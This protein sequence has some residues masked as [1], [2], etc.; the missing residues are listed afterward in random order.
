MFT[1]RVYTNWSRCT[2]DEKYLLLLFMLKLRI[3]PF[4]SKKSIIFVNTV[5]KCY[6]LKLFLERFGIKSCA[7]NAELPIKSRF[8]IV[9]EFNRGIYDFLIATDE[10]NIK[11]EVEEGSE[12]E[13]SPA[14]QQAAG[15]KKRKKRGNKEKDGEYGVSRGIDFKNVSAVINFDIP[16][17][18]RAYHH[19][20]GRT[21][22]GVGIKGHALT[23][24][25]TKV[26]SR[27]IAAKDK[28]NGV[29]QFPDEQVLQR[30]LKK[31]AKLGR[32]ILPFQFDM[33]PVER[34]RYRFKDA[35]RSVT[36]L[37]IKEAR[38]KEIKTELLNSEKLKVIS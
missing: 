4:G 7:L 28:L 17:S 1:S 29:V 22:R 37:A 9:Q 30:I 34:F 11:T 15:S 20:V 31:Q 26:E 14:Q 24:V 19:R 33:V 25:A 13:E 36:A 10:A 8:H 32:T 16:R 6:R 12:D 23:F 38:V 27:S 21:A 2:E 18:S 5:E 35:L 3:D